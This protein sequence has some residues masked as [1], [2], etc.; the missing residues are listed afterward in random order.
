[1]K[2]SEGSSQ[3][4]V[5]SGEMLLFIC[6]LYISLVIPTF[7]YLSYI[8]SCFATYIFELI[9]FIFHY[10]HLYMQPTI[11]LWGVSTCELV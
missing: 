5:I 2:C 9:A 3:L 8:H 1:M 6:V 11:K 4:P 10:K 7:I